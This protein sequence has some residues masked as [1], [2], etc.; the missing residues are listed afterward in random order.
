MPETTKPS[1]RARNLVLAAIAVL[2]V[3][4]TMF[5]LNSDSLKRSA[6]ERSAELVGDLAAKV[7][8]RASDLVNVPVEVRKINDLIYQARGVGNTNL[9]K[10]GA[11]HVI[12]DTGLGTQA[13]KQKRLLLETVGEAPITHI[14]L[15]HSHQDHVGGTQ[16]W[17]QDDTKVVAHREYPEEQ[18]YLKELE[19]FLWSRNRTLFPWIP[20]EPPDISFLEYGNVV[21]TDL[22]A[23][24][25]VYAFDQ[26]GVRFEVLPT[27]GAEGADNVCL[28]LPE[29]KVLFSGDFFGPMF[30]QFP[31]IFT[32]R[33]EKVR[34]PVEYIASL[35]RL[36]A[37]GPEMIIPSHFDPIVGADEIRS[38]MTKIRDA[39][40]Y[41][42]DRT[43][44]GMNAGKTMHELMEEI[45]LPPHLELTQGH[46][47][48]SWGVRSIW[49][50]YATWFKF[51]STTEL[52]PVPKSAVY[53]ELARLSGSGALSG[54]AREH[55][56]A[57]RPVHALHLLEISLANDPAHRPSLEARREALQQL[58]DAAESGLRN[59]YEM[60][61]LK[62]RIRATNEALGEGEAS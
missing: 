19:P 34:K 24:G 4:M 32:M 54:R 6:A 37:L 11:G 3:V 27:P 59:S 2:A 49:E 42:H 29:S 31:N 28:W 14:V 43:V 5:I 55:S 9:V 45:Q 7:M 22:V 23:D 35:D 38:G 53:A 12:F 39:T 51:D 10:T 20:E 62:A 17:Q 25:E 26:G 41:V 50:Y 58:L 30:P 36:I 48:V 61:W 57:E 56:A 40:Q 18:R 52:Y 1:N 47:R 44:A 15:S 8:E 33:G 46:G 16:F 21:P 60:S 13:A